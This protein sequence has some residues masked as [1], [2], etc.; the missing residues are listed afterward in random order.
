MATTL[1]IPDGHGRGVK[2]LIEASLALDHL[3]QMQG[4]L[5]DGRSV[6]AHEPVELR[7]LGQGGEC[8]SQMAL[9][10][11]VEVSL[12]GESRPSGE[13]GEGDDLA[14]GKGGIGAGA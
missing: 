2:S 10:V 11:A 5:L 9:G 14:C 7:A 8:L 6:E 4:Y 12:A 13:D 3:R 1:G